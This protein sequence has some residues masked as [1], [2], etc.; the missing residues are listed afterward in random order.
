MA[1][2]NRIEWMRDFVSLE[3]VLWQRIDARLKE[4]HDLS[5]A[6][7]ESLYFVGGSP[8]G[9][10]RIGDLARALQI[11][12]GAAS[13]LV[14]RIEAAGLIGREADAEDRRASRVVLTEEGKKRLAEA[15]LTH[16][17]ELAQLLDATLSDQEQQQFHSL[18]KRLLAANG[19]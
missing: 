15:S 5:L 19:L 14:D 7:F 11:T 16:Q 4:Q 18:V 1:D 3:I 17:A 8:E 9:S 12:V 2:P 6:F 13:K 10:M